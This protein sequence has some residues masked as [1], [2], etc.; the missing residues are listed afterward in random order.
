MAQEH[1]DRSRR[2][3][4]PAQPVVYEIRL[5]GALEAD[6]WSQ[7][8]D[9]MIVTVDEDGE[10]ILRGPVADQA[11]LYGLLARL[12]DLALPLLSVKRVDPG[13]R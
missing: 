1:K 12:R 5:K 7:W 6:H 9:T 11:A 10:T 8:F 4:P 3:D 13:D 2:G